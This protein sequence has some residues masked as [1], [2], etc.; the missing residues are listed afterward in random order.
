MASKVQQIDL[1]VVIPVYNEEGNVAI[2][3]GNI[4]KVL[5]QLQR[6]YEIIF[7]DDGSRDQTFNIL[8]KIHAAHPRTK[9]IKF[10]G[11]YGQSAAM[12]AGFEAAQGQVVIA[13]DGDLQNDPNDIP[14][15]LEKL[16]AGY[17]VVAGWRRYRKDTLIMRKV[18]SRLANKLICSVTGVKLHDTGCSLKLFRREIIKKIRLYGELHR[19]IPALAKIE[20]ARIT[21]LEVEHHE[22]RFGVSKYNISRTFRVIMDLI[23]IN[24]LMKHLRQPIH[25]FGGLGVFN[26]AIG[27]FTVMALIFQALVRNADA[28]YLNVLMTIAFVFLVSGVGLMVLGLLANLIVE[29]GMRK[30][31][32]LA[33]LGDATYLTDTK[34]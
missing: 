27:T 33:E 25:F 28:S 26:I 19:F 3:Q 10:R 31:V 16:E 5:D 29:T 22:R 8:E 23:T 7:V 14:R 6:E 11:N 18:P 34:I 17:D 32:Y 21:E 15:M 13:M 1:S 20:G 12:A 2:L 24:L 30:H 9:V 4:R